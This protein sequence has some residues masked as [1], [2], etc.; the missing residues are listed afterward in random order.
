MNVLMIGQHAGVFRALDPVVRELCR[1]GHQVVLLHGTPLHSL[2]VLEIPGV[3]SRERPEPSEAWPRRLRVGRQVINRGIYWHKGH[4]SPE[5]VAAR[6]ENHL[7]DDVRAKVQTPL[8]RSAIGTRAALRVWR[9]I[10]AASPA[11]PT[12]VPL[13]QEIDPDVMLVSPAVWPTD[14]VEADYVRAGRALGIPTVGYASSWDDLTSQGTVHLLPDLHVVWNEPMAQEAVDIHDIPASA[15]RITG[16]PHLDTFFSLRPRETRAALCAAL[17]CRDEP[18]VLFLGSP[19]TLWDDESFVVRALADALAREFAAN[20]PTLIVR[21]DPANATPFHAFTHQGVVI[22]RSGGDQ[23]DSPA[24]VQKSFDTVAHATCVFGLNTP[25]FLEAVVVD[26]PCLTIVS[27]TYWPAQGRTGHFR[28]LLK[29]QLLDICRDM[30]DVAACVRRILDGAD[31]HATGRREFRRWFLRPCG[32]ESAASEVVADVI[33]R[34]ARRRPGSTGQ[35]DTPRTLIPGL[36]LAN[37]L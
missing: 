4:P 36:T 12:I 23:A 30:G 18:Y 27:D 32:V 2:Q 24:S 7:P 22:D 21:P 28:H 29:G 34:A 11:S 33:E 25:A 1:R 10:E 13:L 8:W 5:R 9:W 26:R 3:T 20:A 6:L 14:P 35:R 16:A 15:I 17:G 19:R 31:D 37:S